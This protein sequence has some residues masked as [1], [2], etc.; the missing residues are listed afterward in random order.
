[1][2]HARWGLLATA[3]SAL[4]LG[5]LVLA[6]T[7]ASTYHLLKTYPLGGGDAKTEYWDYMTFDE[8]TRHLYLS[9]GTEVRVVNADTG[10]IVGTIPGFQR[11]HGIALVKDLNKGFV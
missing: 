10:E 1:M 3:A 2:K 11:N 9:H 5:G 7:A 6:R 4:V 8:S